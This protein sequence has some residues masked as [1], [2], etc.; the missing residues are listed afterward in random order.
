ME[1]PTRGDYHH[2]HED[3]NVETTHSAVILRF[4][5]EHG[6]DL[7]ARRSREI[8]SERIH[9]LLRLSDRKARNGRI[10]HEVRRH[11]IL[12]VRRGNQRVGRDFRKIEA[13]GPASPFPIR[14]GNR[15]FD[16]SVILLISGLVD[17]TS[18]SRQRLSHRIDCD[19]LRVCQHGTIP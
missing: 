11:R 12:D 17:A 18:N 9:D 13:D 2:E 5:T 16:V 14:M 4:A 1:D 6:G 3:E 15:K 8:R 7:G 19:R 10:D